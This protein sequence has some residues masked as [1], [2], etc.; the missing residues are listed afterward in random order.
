[1]S[2]YIEE[3]LESKIMKKAIVLS[4][5]AGLHNQI[6]RISVYD[7]PVRE[8]VLERKILKK[9]DLLI[10]SLFFQKSSGTMVNS[11][12]KMLYDAGCCGICVSNQYLTK[13]PHEVLEYSDTISFPIIQFDMSISYAEIIETTMELIITNKEY[14]V[15][16]LQI[17]KLLNNKLSTAEIRETASIMNSNF[18]E[19]NCVI[20]INN[21]ILKKEQISSKGLMNYLNSNLEYSAFYYKNAI[22]II[23]TFHSDNEKFIKNSIEVIISDVERYY[24]EYHMGISSIHKSLNTLN[25]AVNEGIFSYRNSKAFDR[26]ISYYDE[27]KINRLLLSIENNKEMEKYYS[28]M[29]DPVKEYDRQ[30]NGDLLKTLISFFENNGDY[31]KIAEETY[32]HPNTIRYKIKMVKSI[33]DMK[34]NN[35]EFYTSMSLAIKIG[36]LLNK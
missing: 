15:N 3:L 29:V 2:I 12:I 23:L 34:D 36:K 10:T 17:E 4:G 14:L 16:E 22:I 13:L 18:K 31:K 1:M 30:F 33:L 26:K 32:Q 19:N 24:E 21:C 27:I 7:S 11:F 25:E 6:E 28:I 5:K 9:G 20:Y 35:I 8:D